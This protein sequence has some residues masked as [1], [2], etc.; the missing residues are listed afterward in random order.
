MIK[1]LILCCLFIQITDASNIY[2]S[3]EQRSYLEQKRV[4]T[5]C[6]DPEWEPFEKIND[7]KEHE[8]IA[9]D[10]LRLIADRLGITIQLIPTTTWQESIKKSQ[11]YECDIIS[12]VNQ[13]PKRDQWLIYTDT[14][15]KDPNVLIAR[16][17]HSYIDD[18]S[19][20]KKHSIALL[21]DTAILERFQNDFPNIKVI[22]VI[23][24]EE[25]FKLVE[26][27][28]VD[29]TL[30]S[31]MVA[32]YTIK[33]ENLF[34][35]KI[36]G[37][38]ENYTNF[39]RIGVHKDEPIL[40]N[41]L[42][43]GV[44]SISEEE[45]QHIVDKYIYIK[46]ETGKNYYRWF[47]YTI[48]LLG[49]VLLFILL[50]NHQLRKRVDKEVQKNLEH[51]KQ[52]FQ[53]SKQAVLGNLMANISHQWRDNLTKI[54]YIN[55]NLRAHI[56]QKKEIPAV[57][58]DT[59]TQEIE[60]TID[61]MSE[62]MQNFLE[63]YKPSTN[64]QRF[65]VCDSIKAVIQI[66]DTRIKKLNIEISFTI[67]A[68]AYIQGIRNEWM[69]VWMNILSNT[70]NIAQKRSISYAKITIIIDQNRVTFE[71]NC[72]GIEA[73]ILKD[74]THEVYQGLG[75]KMCKDIITKYNGHFIIENK[76]DGVCSSILLK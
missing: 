57:L 16:N 45:Y 42:N 17:E 68:D 5:M 34:N 8:G 47:I 10:I 43:L 71:D 46:L 19:K 2:I 24:E 62:T 55:L 9:A 59:S 12:L 29:L 50:W 44:Q 64:S 38:P 32:A 36:V 70:L 14:I 3:E 28:K 74:I 39:L 18:I 13:T 15:I 51:S 35:L 21:K 20:L 54:S 65:E 7:K 72:G 11:N 25:A 49:C 26:E 53:Q 31:L 4:I 75:I 48:L 40:R 61:F 73:S 63:Y 22:P 66:L 27:K 41:I 1:K 30:R 37:K 60:Q 56:M 58:L 76:N 52:F 23:T 33:K 67:I 6:V 69:Q